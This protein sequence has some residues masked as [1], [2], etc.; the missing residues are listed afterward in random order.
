VSFLQNIYKP[1]WNNILSL[2]FWRQG[3]Y[4][5]GVTS[6]SPAVK[7]HPVEAK[8]I[9]EATVFAL[10]LGTVI[11]QLRQQRSW[12]QGQLAAAVG[13]SQPFISRIEA[14]RIQPDVFLY[15]KLAEALGMTVEVLNRQ[16]N[17]A[18]SAAKRAAE[19][20]SDGGKSWDD[21][22]AIVGM[23]GLIGLI[24]FAVAALLDGAGGK[25]PKP[26]VG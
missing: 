23:I 21:V 4:Y 12:T 17:D 14:G 15:G 9:E 26:R 1:C 13:V 22:F 7:K 10:V 5:S 6:R 25:I 19:A 3:T 11:A 16:V 18:M 24:V 20:V 8:R 2:G